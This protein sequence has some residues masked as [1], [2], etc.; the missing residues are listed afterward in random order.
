MSAIVYPTSLPGPSVAPIQS[1]ERRNVSPLDGPRATAVGQRDRLATQQV[2]FVFTFAEAAV[3]RAWWKDTLVYGGA[4][5]AAT[6]PLP[7]GLIVGVRKFLGTPK[8]SEYLPNVGWRVMAV[9]EVRARGELPVAQ[10]TYTVDLDATVNVGTSSVVGVLLSGLDPA[11]AYTLSMPAGLT[12]VAWRP[13]TVSTPNRYLNDLR[14][15]SAAGDASYGSAADFAT[16]AAARAA[17]PGGTITGH[18]SY[19]FWIYDTPTTDNDG[20]L[21]VTLTG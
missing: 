1:A 7:Q 5:F 20:G 10:E 19:T 16:A 6:W 13:N 8:W 4:W 12:Y 21:S 17:F 11:V 2:A 9:C 15:T 18:A 14:V 3:F